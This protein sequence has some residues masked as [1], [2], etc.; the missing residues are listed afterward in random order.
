MAEANRPPLQIR[1]AGPLGI[2]QLEAGLRRLN[3]GADR[4]IFWDENIAAFRETVL[5]ALRETSDAL[6]S[7][8]VPEGCRAE[9]ESQIEALRHYVELADGYVE[10]RALCSRIN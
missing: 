9:L 5:L 3:S 7:P 4:T 10:R 2:G 8:R 1:K 6:R